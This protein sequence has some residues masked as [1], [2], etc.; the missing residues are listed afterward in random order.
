MPVS[1]TAAPIA[2]ALCLLC[3]ASGRAATPPQ[4]LDPVVAVAEGRLKGEWTSTGSAIFRGIPYAAPPVGDLRWRPP[5]RPAL[6][7]GVRDARPSAPPCLQASLGWNVADAERSAEDCLTIDVR[8][9]H[10]DPKAHLPVLVWIHGGGNWGG[11]AGWVIDSALADRGLVVV[12]IQY[13]LGILGFL[14]HPHLS[15]E[16]PYAVSGNY[17]L[18]DQIAG[19]KWVQKNIAAFGGDPRSVTLAGHSAGAQ[20][21]GLLMLVPE[22]RGLFARAIQQSGTAGFGLPSRPLAEN[23]SLGKQFTKL[24]GVAAGEDDIASL[25]ALPARKLLDAQMQLETG[26]LADDS[27]I[28]L[29][30]VVDGRIVPAPPEDLLRAGRSAPVPLM[31]GN[32]AQELAL[33]SGDSSVWRVVARGF[34][35]SAPV[36][37]TLYGLVNGLQPPEDALLGSAAMQ[38]ADD[39]TFRCPAAFTA[40]MHTQSG[41]PIWRYQMER[42]AP[43]ATRIDHGAELTF[44]FGNQ[45]LDA[46]VDA[47]QPFLPAYWV[48]FIRTGDPNGP[49]LPRWPRY[50]TSRDYVRFTAHG[51]VADRGL[52]AQICALLERP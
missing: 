44:I 20:D 27:Y 19:L 9:S 48:N 36:A 41:Q 22:A 31:I 34:G 43:G 39:L 1:R 21:V 33:N 50:G 6:W 46:A 7:T 35:R 25:R 13:R 26:T 23:E 49:D 16:S 8:T 45:P 15:R 40:D 30:A 11:S 47:R 38:I 42:A 5:Q 29:Q 51:P 24:A 52:R 10:L 28:F 17:A 3:H 12:T 18:M 4:P 32:A 14:S 2:I 37:G